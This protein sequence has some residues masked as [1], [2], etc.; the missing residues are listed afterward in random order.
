M[1][2]VAITA[3]GNF[4]LFHTFAE[5]FSVGVAFAIFAVTVNSVVA[6]AR[7]PLLLLAVAFASAALLDLLHILSYKGMGIFQGFDANAPTQL[8]I[9]ARGLQAV[10]VAAAFLVPSGLFGLKRVLAVYAVVLAV[11]T[12]SVFGWRNFPD[13]YIEGSGL[14]GFKIAS[15]YAICA[16]LVLSGGLL[17]RRRSRFDEHML[18]WTLASLAFTVVSELAFT[19]YVGVY[20]LSNIVGHL[21]KVV[22][23]YCLYVAVVEKAVAEPQR[24]LFRDLERERARYK[25]LAERLAES[26]ADLEQFARA[27]SHDLKAPL[28][29]ASGYLQMVAHRY[30]A[31][32]PRE[33][34]DWLASANTGVSRMNRMINDLLT[35][36]RLRD[37]DHCPQPVP[38]DGV[39]A[40]VADILEPSLRAV[41]GRIVVGGGLPVVMGDSNQLSR[42]F[43]NLI[44]NAQKYS[45]PDLPPE[46]RVHSWAE[47]D[48]ASITVTDNG[49]GFRSDEADR[50]FDPF[51]RGANVSGQEGTGIGLA[52]C[53]RIVAQHGGAIGIESPGPG[54]GCIVR[55]RLPLWTPAMA[56]C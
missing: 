37:A 21:A 15:E 42:L 22:A 45:R 35:Y 25:A 11:I 17:V 53:R 31:S 24:V 50:L 47:G 49:I 12:Q 33:V 6:V 29:A 30:G 20:D 28:N 27:V 2:L 46:I 8:W 48:S 7:G 9:A 44:G 10:S 14:T 36:S 1:G 34:V 56:M 52:L 19:L 38:L 5:V 51:R 40:E 43:L 26:N 13:C 23:F 41:G 55:L 54:Q 4:L 16:V 32:L 18:R 3:S 39:M